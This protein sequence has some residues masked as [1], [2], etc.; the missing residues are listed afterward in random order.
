M[1]ISFSSYQLQTLSSLN[2]TGAKGLR[3][4]ALLKVEWKED[5]L[6]G[7]ADLH[8]WPELGDIPL[9][10]QLDGVRQGKISLQLEQ[11]IWLAHRD[12][13]LRKDKKNV[14]DNG[15]KVKNNFVISDLTTLKPGFLDSINGEAFTHVKIKV[16]RDLAKESDL[17]TQVAAAG[18]RVRLDF[19]GMGSWQTFEK[20]MT[21]VP[22]TVL[23]SI[24]Y[25]EDPFAYDHQAWSD[26]KK[27]VKIAVDNQYDKVPWE[28]LDKAPFD[29]VVIKPAKTDVAKAIAHCRTHNLKAV[30]TSY[31]DHPV[32]MIHALGVAMEL[33]KL[34]GDMMLDPGCLT[35]QLFKMDVYAAEIN[36]QGPFVMK[37]KGTGVGFNDLLG[38]QTWHHLK[39]N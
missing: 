27:I 8:P 4:G 10:E 20:F 12:A 18:L 24:E 32:G 7:Y 36:T 33:K 11:S 14:F 38:A 29:V 19:N 1:K 37:V 30:V 9:A 15:V 13:I 16:G 21:S 35:H 6:I 17:L 39:L 34:Y 31:M 26:A 25:V 28:T 23:P 3:D 2:S 5:G 22:K